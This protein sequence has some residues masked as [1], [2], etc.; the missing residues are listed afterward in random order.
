MGTINNLQA[1]KINKLITSLNYTLVVLGPA[2]GTQSA[3][4]AY[5]FAQALLLTTPHTIKNI[6]FY[7]DGVYNGNRYTDPANDE[8]DLISAWQELAKKYDLPLTICVA[9]S[10]RRGIT[11][12]NIADYFQLTGLGEL[13]ESITLSDRV[14]Q[15]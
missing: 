6:F 4:C 13:T 7:A 9:A 11:E 8:F 15:F 10:L 5:Q 1:N 12:E 14:I 3:Y 2:Y